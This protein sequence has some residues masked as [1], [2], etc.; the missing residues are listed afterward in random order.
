M[1][2]DKIFWHANC[3]CQKWVYTEFYGFWKTHSHLHFQNPTCYHNNPK[4][5]TALLATLNSGKEPQY[6]ERST[7]YLALNWTTISMLKKRRNR[8][9]VVTAASKSKAISVQR[10]SIREFQFQFKQRSHLTVYNRNRTN[11]S[12]TDAHETNN[13]ILMCKYMTFF[14]LS[15]EIEL[16]GFISNYCETLSHRQCA[17]KT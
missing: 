11:L 16:Y 14:Q 3:L 8:A 17:W 12:Y 5:L 13:N 1:R 9:M 15:F 4:R 2:V 6:I 10:N 7:F